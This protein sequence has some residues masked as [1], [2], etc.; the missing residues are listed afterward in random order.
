[1]TDES[2]SVLSLLPRLL[3]IVGCE[4]IESREIREG[5]RFEHTG[6]GFRFA[7]KNDS[8]THCI[9]SAMPK[10]GRRRRQQ[11]SGE[12]RSHDWAQSP[13]GHRGRA[14]RAYHLNLLQ[15]FRASSYDKQ[16]ESPQ[17]DLN[18]DVALCA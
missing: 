2:V 16:Q 5:P 4:Q 17:R 18:T 6:I 1:M 14:F 13:H 11:T 10:L 12:Q 8:I 3:P 15:A 7:N 9:V